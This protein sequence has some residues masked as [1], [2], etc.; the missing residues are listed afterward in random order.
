MS[1][2]FFS[3]PITEI[4]TETRDCRVLKFDIP[5]DLKKQLR[6]RAGQYFTLRV[7]IG[8]GSVQRAYSLCSAPYENKWEVAVKKVP[9]GAFS[10]YVHN[11][12]RSGDSIEIMGPDGNFVL[13]ADPESKRRYTFFAAGSGITPVISLIKDVLYRESASNVTLFYANKTKDDIIFKDELAALEKEYSNRFKVFHFLT[14]ETHEKTLFCGRL[15]AKKCKTLILNAILD[16]DNTDKFMLCGPE[17]MVFNIKTF[18]QEQGVVDSKIKFELFTTD[19]SQKNKG[20]KTGTSGSTDKGKY[21][22]VRITLDGSTTT[23]EVPYD[24]MSILEW[25][26]E[27]GLPVPYSCQS[28]TCSTCRARLLE[29]K[30]EMM[31]NFVLDEEEVAE[32]Y[33]LTCQSLP[34]SEKIHLDYDQ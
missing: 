7:N 12:L 24:D 5:E 34:K 18:L 10:E 4:K 23:I 6:Y 16:I 3:V 13:E 14:R 32:G 30:V 1:H 29:G 27:Y 31:V 17:A 33:R 21:S 9:G 22:K 20:K 25:A 11:E 15:N 8:G 2:S 19:A 26:M 28:G